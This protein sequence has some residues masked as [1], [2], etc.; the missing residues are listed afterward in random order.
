[1]IESEK[2]AS[3]KDR[4]KREREREKK[5]ERERERLRPM[6]WNDDGGDDDDD[7]DGIT[8]R[9]QI[10]THAERTSKRQRI[11]VIWNVI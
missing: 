8:H 4:G 2:K 7:D 5:S 3:K 1:M 10:M 9:P 6:R 11:Q